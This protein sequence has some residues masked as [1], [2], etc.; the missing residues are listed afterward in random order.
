MPQKQKGRSSQNF[1]FANEVGRGLAEESRAAFVGLICVFD[2][3]GADKQRGWWKNGK[4]GGSV[5]LLLSVRIH[6]NLPNAA[7]VNK[8]PITVFS[9]I[10][11]Y[12]HIKAASVNVGG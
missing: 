4:E 2:L 9:G 10:S 8:T 7:N 1:S 11:F 6:M 5:W 3:G 12:F